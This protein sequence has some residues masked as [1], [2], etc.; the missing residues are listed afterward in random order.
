M[1]YTGSYTLAFPDFNPAT[2]PA[3][4]AGWVDVS[5]K[6]DA[7]PCFWHRVHKLRLWIDYAEPAD[8]EVP[9]QPRFT[10]VPCN[11]AMDEVDHPLFQTDEWGVILSAIATL[12]GRELK[13]A[14]DTAL[15]AGCT[16][17]EN[18]VRCPDGEVWEWDH[19]HDDDETWEA[20]CAHLGLACA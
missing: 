10:L 11:D 4:P 5:W 9:D 14:K 17:T 7:C 8:R 2:M 1:T 16:E 18:G 15:A 3:I 6:H 19:Y 20:A 13:S 12:D